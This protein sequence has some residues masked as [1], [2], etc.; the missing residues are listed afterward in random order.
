M[1]A[2]YYS[3]VLVQRKDILKK[4]RTPREAHQGSFVLARQ[5]PGAPGTFNPEETG[6]PGL[7]VS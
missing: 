4:K 3:S 6:L 1:N 5:F 2:E 7:P